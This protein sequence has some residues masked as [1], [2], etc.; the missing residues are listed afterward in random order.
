MQEKTTF[1]NES[2][3]NGKK[4]TRQKG[5]K[6]GQSVNVDNSRNVIIIQ[7]GDQS[8][9]TY[10]PGSIPQPA[11][12]PENFSVQTYTACYDLHVAKKIAGCLVGV[13][14]HECPVFLTLKTL[15]AVNADLTQ[16]T[17]LL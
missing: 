6:R 12:Q 1:S 7:H 9:P 15:V 14:Q 17:L 13:T 10:M 5:K 8:H 2:K 16:K 3:A 11:S 4:K